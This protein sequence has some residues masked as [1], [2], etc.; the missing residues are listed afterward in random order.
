MQS[1]SLNISL[2]IWV[3]ILAGVL[4][5]F[6]SGEQQKSSARWV[7]LLGS[8]LGLAV[9]IPLWVGFDNASSAMQ[10]VERTSWV[11]R[12]NINYAVGVDGI[13]MLFVLLNSFTDRK[14][15]V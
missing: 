4:T 6:L 9:A 14:S 3:P 15:V 2:T 10:F 7:A 11:S 12:F 8:L 1:S 13:S 5:L